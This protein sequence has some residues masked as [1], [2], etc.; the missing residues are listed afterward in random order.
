MTKKEFDA[1]VKQMHQQGLD[2]DMIMK[3]LYEAFITNKCNFDD[4]ELMVNWLG[5][6]LTD[7]F[8]KAHN[9]KR[10]AQYN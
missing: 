9:I 1:M 10:N 5:Y 3:I 4:Y 2:D 7:D 6:E 8:L